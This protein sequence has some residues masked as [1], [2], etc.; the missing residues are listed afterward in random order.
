MKVE[1]ITTRVVHVNSPAFRDNPAAIYI[2][3]AARRANDVRCRYRSPF[4]NPFPLVEGAIDKAQSLRLYEREMRQRME[5]GGCGVSSDDYHT[6]PE[7]RAMIVRLQG[8]TLGCWCAPEPCHGDVLVR[9]V[10]ELCG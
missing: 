5:E 9:L 7:W 6:G 10:N 4:A 1:N 2:G 8:R 3:R